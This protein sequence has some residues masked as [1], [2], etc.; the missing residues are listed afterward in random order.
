MEFLDFLQGNGE[1]ILFRLSSEC[2]REVERYLMALILVLRE[3]R[4]Q[5]EV[6]SHFERLRK[7]AKDCESGVLRDRSNSNWTC[8]H[9]HSVLGV[10]ASLRHPL[11]RPPTLEA[12][13]RP[14][15]PLS[16]KTQGKWLIR[17][18][19]TQNEPDGCVKSAEIRHVPFKSQFDFYGENGRCGIDGRRR[20]FVRL[21]YQALLVQEEGDTSV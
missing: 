2:S 21:N 15:T 11:R 19:Q 9:D 4:C 7:I 3:N 14:G 6:S 18:L 5:D 16:D 1:S 20:V 13:S 12:K 17:S 10:D 8:S